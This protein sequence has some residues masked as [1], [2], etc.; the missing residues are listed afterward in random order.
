MVALL[1]GDL[2]VVYRKTDRR[3]Q[4]LHQTTPPVM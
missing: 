1:R 2:N 3:H 4:R